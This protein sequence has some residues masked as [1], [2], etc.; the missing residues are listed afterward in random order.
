M[1]NLYRGLILDIDG[2]LILNNRALPYAADTI[3]LLREK[4]FTIRFLS[5][6]TSRSPQQLSDAL[7]EK[8]IFSKNHE[9]ITSVSVCIDYLEKNFQDMNGF[10]AVPER[11][12]SFFS[13]LPKCQDNP[14][15]VV[16]G[17][18]DEE[19]DYAVLNK[20]FN[21]I[22]GGAKLLAFH[23]NLWFYRDDKI[24]LD[25][26]A[27]LHSLEFASNTEACVIGK[28]S[29][30]VFENVLASMG[31][32]NEEI[33]VVG[34][35]VST[36]IAGASNSNLKSLLVKS[37][38]YRESDLENPHVASDHVIS[39]IADLPNWLLKNGGMQ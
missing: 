9:V 27:F 17:D 25:S 8:G 37:G 31:L 15:Y 19:F 10:F 11:V 22:R 20:L 16:L 36:D 18:L 2:T 13:H 29:S 28:P 38:K 33:L 12:K 24:F 6:T 1:S 4:D 34:D 14:D 26:G 30:I 35:D 21:F 3:N 23:K 39:G 5:N 32:P 7:N